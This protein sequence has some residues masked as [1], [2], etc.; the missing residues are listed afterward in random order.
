MI[1]NIKLCNPSK[2]Y[3]IISLLILMII[4]F[5]EQYNFSII[6]INDNCNKKN[7]KWIIPIKILYI[8]F[9]TFILNVLCMYGY[10]SISW[11]LLLFPYVLFFIF[12]LMVV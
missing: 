11:I 7:T 1:E 2:Y 3:L 5:H 10:E 4:A 12:Y 8:L 9:W 6:C